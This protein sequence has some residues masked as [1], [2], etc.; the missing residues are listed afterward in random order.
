MKN[1]V[2]LFLWGMQNE[3]RKGQAKEKH[4]YD[5]VHRNFLMP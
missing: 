4:I 2:C 1:K 3:Q 5:K